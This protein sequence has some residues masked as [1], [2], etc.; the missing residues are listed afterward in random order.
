MKDNDGTTYVSSSHIVGAHV[1][2]HG[3]LAQ[4]ITKPGRRKGGHLDQS[5]KDHVCRR[6]F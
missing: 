3:Q 2:P 4:T 6:I 5:S 1:F